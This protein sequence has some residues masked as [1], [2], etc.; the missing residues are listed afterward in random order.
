MFDYYLCWDILVWTTFW[1][2]TQKL[3]D[4]GYPFENIMT[5]LESVTRWFDVDGSLLMA[6][7]LLLM[8]VA[9]MLRWIFFK[10]ISEELNNLIWKFDHV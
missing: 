9:F 1:H 8:A 7:E 10:G 5:W 3:V 2:A 4:C 6:D